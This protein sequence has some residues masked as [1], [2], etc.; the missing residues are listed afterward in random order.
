MRN[1]IK[2]ILKEEE[3]FDWISKPQ[4]AN[5]NQITSALTPLLDDGVNRDTL[6]SLVNLVNDF[7]IT[8]GQLEIFGTLINNIAFGVRE[9][10][11]DR[12]VQAG[13]ESGREDGYDDGWSE[14]HRD[15][16][17]EGYEDCQNE[18][19]EAR[20]DGYEEGKED[21]FEKGYRRGYREASEEVYNKAFE[22]GR[23]YQSDLEA[24]EYERRQDPFTRFDD[25]DEY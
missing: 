6:K 18:V 19:E 12:G 21:G 24:E 13:W 1:R 25:E 17:N 2:K 22:E 15:G 5:E 11:F 4:K 14:G 10:T 9:Y 7:E 23:Q 16:M 8:E 3:D 20:Y